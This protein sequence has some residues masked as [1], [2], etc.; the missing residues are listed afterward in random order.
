[1][2]L[3][4]ILNALRRYW[5]IFVVV[6]AVGAGAGFATSDRETTAFE[7]RAVLL[8]SPP[9]ESRVQVSFTNDPDRYVIG[10]LSVLRSDD[11]AERVANQVGDGA[12][13]AGIRATTAIEHEPQT[14]IVSVIT[15]ANTP[16]RARA[17]AAAYVDQYFQS[18]DEQVSET[19]QPEIDELTTELRQLETDVAGVDAQ[20][21]TA[22]APFLPTGAEPGNAGYAPIPGVDQVV[23][24][25][26]SKR[27]ILLSQ[28]DQ[29]LATRTQLTELDINAK[30]RVTS[31]VVQS[32]TLSDTPVKESGRLRIAA[33]AIAGAFLGLILVVLV[34]RSSRT[35][36]DVREIEE[37]LG[38]PV[39][40]EFPAART[41]VKNRKAIIEALPHGVASF[42]DEV[43][44]RAEAHAHV[45]GA[46]TVAVVG[47]ERS[48]GCTTLAGALAN[49]YAASG[50][51]VV[52][53]DADVRNSEL[54][55]LFAAGRPGIPA[56]LAAAGGDGSRG[57]SGGRLDPFSPT[58][59]PG[60][61]VV[62]VGDKTANGALRRQQVPELLEAASAASHVVV[63][64]CGPV[65]DSAS[66]VQLIQ[67]VDAVVLAVPTRRLL[68]RSLATLAAQLRGRRGG[69]LPVLMPVARRRSRRGGG[70]STPAPALGI[71]GEPSVS[72]AAR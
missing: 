34:A 5:W 67:M 38:Q 72:K 65:L 31:E 26:A 1:M 6:A 9:S 18:L 66:T 71:A 3:V 70:T 49:R 23:P 39:V 11:L 47:T 46:F 48:A 60:L 19:R 32:A 52:L 2:E 58:S 24:D 69:L 42:A 61:V 45:G 20:I 13:T 33:G 43:A 30:L 54:S 56:L 27:Q 40:G 41:L 62:G 50:S 7:S 15:K 16:D 25:L 68:T 36:L 8:V 17:I 14:D 64:D 35:A 4:F 51:L 37:A 53:V 55:R 59:I 10:Q 63:F 21:A 22:M 57:T 44:V 12:S 29:V 28:Y